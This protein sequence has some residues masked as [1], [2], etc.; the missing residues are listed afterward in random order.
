[1]LEI[2][3]CM[4]EQPEQDEIIGQINEL[5][6]VP[7]DEL[8]DEPQDESV[9]VVKPVVE[10]SK[11]KLYFINEVVEM[12]LT[13]YLWSGCT[14]VAL[15]DKIMANAPE[16][17][18][19]MIRKQGLHTIYPGQEESAFGDL[20]QTAWCQLERTL[21]KYR[22]RP[23]C[24]KC[25]NPDRPSDSL[26]YEPG[27]NE[28]GIKT[29]EEVIA[30]M[31][32]GCCKHCGVKLSVEPIVEPSQDIYGGSETILYRGMSKVFNMWS[33]IS[34]TVILAY[35][36]KECRDNKNSPTY[37]THLGSKT[38]STNNAI[39]RFMIEI[40]ELWKYNKEYIRIIDAIELLIQNDEKPHD[41]IIGKLVDITK[42][43]RQTVIDFINLTK[44]RSFE[45]SDSNINNGTDDKKFDKRKNANDHED[46]S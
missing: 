20:A 9:D 36:K 40:R 29:M 21:Y 12:D 28:Y 41:G 45:L 22:S 18:R 42:I 17:I 19:Q 35:V 44:L 25:Y 7:I 32:N 8:S 15:R 4:S 13:K 6:D 33:Q 37:I 46:E 3:I 16:L 1:M 30:L 23:H 5:A 43:S 2:G 27:E 14:D 31:P 38:K 39:S 10:V 11:R 24:R 26:L 34:R